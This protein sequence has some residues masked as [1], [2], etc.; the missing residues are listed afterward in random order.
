MRRIYFEEAY[1]IDAEVRAAIAE[2]RRRA[3][4]VAP[5]L[6]R[7]KHKMIRDQ[8]SG[9][10]CFTMVDAAAMMGI[11]A[12]GT[13][14]AL[15]RGGAI[16]WTVAG[17]T[18]VCQDD[19]FAVLQLRSDK[20][21]KSRGLPPGGL[22]KDPLLVPISMAADKIGVTVRT[23]RRRAASGKL[24]LVTSGSK[25]WLRRHEVDAL[26]AA[27]AA[28][29]ARAAEARDRRRAA[30]ARGAN[31]TDAHVENFMAW[32]K[33]SQPDIDPALALHTL[34]RCCVRRCSTECH[35]DTC[36]RRTAAGPAARPRLADPHCR[37][38]CSRGVQRQGGADVPEAADR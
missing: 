12:S 7:R 20:I 9:L 25:L 23:L 29:P 15:Q 22:M 26:V 17:A 3:D 8:V 32:L 34:Q 38:G 11:S 18:R 14:K 6:L 21:R 5:D 10:Q 16:T 19:L 1:R 35:R 2:N 37:S 13:R 4:G 28:K 24:E 30:A 33:W 27:Q 36:R 31:L